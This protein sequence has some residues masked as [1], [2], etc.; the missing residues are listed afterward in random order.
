MPCRNE[1][2]GL[3][4]GLAGHFVSRNNDVDGYWGLGIFY[5]LAFEKGAGRFSLDLL[6]GRSSLPFR[7]SARIARQ[8]KDYLLQR[9]AKMGFEKFQLTAAIVELEFNVHPTARQ[10]LFKNTR[11]DAYTCRVVLTDDLGKKREFKTSG[12]CG[13]HDPKKEIRS[14]RRYS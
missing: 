7:Y 14:T 1:L 2:K 6:S 10:V 5:K 11:G 3:A 12:W 9:L 4:A 13:Q 8:Y